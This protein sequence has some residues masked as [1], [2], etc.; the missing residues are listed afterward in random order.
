M[1]CDKGEEGRLSWLRGLWKT[2]DNCRTMGIRVSS[3][4]LIFALFRPIRAGTVLTLLLE[5]FLWRRNHLTKLID[6]SERSRLVLQPG[7]VKERS[8]S[9][10]CAMRVHQ[11]I[12]E[13]LNLLFQLSKNESQSN[14]KSDTRGS[15]RNSTI[16]T[17]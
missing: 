14:L 12:K 6:Q 7:K 11:S 8:T 13:A 1:A 9:S 17:G 3:R 4:D 2:R 16:V 15:R 10:V 5:N